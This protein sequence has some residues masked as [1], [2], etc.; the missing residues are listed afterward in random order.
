MKQDLITQAIAFISP[1]AAMSRMI[2]QAKLRNFGRFDSA[3]DSTKRGISRNVSGAEDTAGTT[4]RY[5][6]IRA[7]RD[8]AD[9]FPPI[10]SLLLKFA[11][12][13]AGRL[14]YQART[15][16]RDLDMK[17]ERYWRNWCSKCDF[18]RRFDFVTLLQLAVMAVL[19][20][21]DCGFVIVRDQGELRLQSVESDRIGSPYNR[22]IDSDNYIG[23]IV[24]D[25]YG[26]PDQY[27]LYVRTISNQYIDPT[28]IP[29]AE[30]IHLFDPTRLDEYRGRSAFATALNAARDLQEALK[31]EIQAIKFASYQT[32]IIMSETGAAEASDY[33]ASSQ[34]N[35]YGQRAKLESVDP[36]TMNYL[37][38][39]EKME[40]F[41]NTRPTGAF[42]EFVRLVQSHICMSVGLPYGFSFD[43]DKSGPMA[44]MEAEM[45]DRTF[46]RWRRL[47]ETQFLDRIKNIV[48]LD[49]ASRGLIP[50]N[51]YLLDGRW[52]WPRKASIDYGREARADIDLWKAGLKTAAQ[53]YSEGGEDYEE[54]LRTRA[55]EASMIV[56]LAAEYQIPA[57]Y[58]SDSVPIANSRQAEPVVPTV[59]EPQT[60][61]A[62][63]PAPAPTEAKAAFEDSFKPTAGMIAEAEKGLEWREKFKRGGT[64][65]GVAR[66]RDI[67]NGKNLSEDTVKRMHSFFSRH[68]VDKKGEGFQQ[69]EDGFPSAGR[70]A[71]ALWGGD[72]GQV[73]AAD[74][75]KGIRLATRP[76]VKEFAVVVNDVYGRFAAVQHETA[77]VMPEPGPREQEE[78][79]ID[80]C[81]VNA[82]ME[83]EYPDFDQ[84]LAVCMTQLAVVG[85]R[86]GIKASPKAPKSDTPNKD[87]QGEGTAKGDA[88]GKRGAE[89][90]AEQEKT[91]QNKADE[92]NEKDSNTKNGRATLGALKS[93]FQRGLGAF[94]TSHSPRVQSAEQWAFA[95]V[96]AFLYLLKNG[97]PENPKYT[98]DNDLLPKEH[99][100][101][102]K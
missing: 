56:D 50:D 28:R 30:F 21:G 6:L 93:V 43:A 89:V 74:K 8:L 1:Q 12:Y 96:N 101:A 51:E 33:F 26:R 44:R 63:G 72:A 68:E 3:L 18:L 11:T 2:S 29:A 35:D 100:K 9:N 65:I 98:T 88:S 55:K 53:I 15:G 70:I 82:T 69:G 17:I 48:L 52:G 99:P 16:D 24:L 31:A 78:D 91:L 83:S 66:A 39:G 19:R 76:E 95:R 73:W 22:L 4:E 14:N 36:G 20:D 41:E 80:R 34:P 25:D 46:A 97:R 23:G 86:G 5:K 40:M 79:F 84:R 61:P 37:S 32:G 92:F 38:P 60:E 67:S 10:R 13:V 45:A 58:I 27:E 94:N 87:P 71:W 85:E 57:Q 54:A 81:M 47:L 59:T 7:A 42:G 75:M 77:M 90:T 102:Q 64:S 49:A 62:E